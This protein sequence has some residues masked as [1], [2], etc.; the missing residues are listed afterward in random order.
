MLPE[1]RF[2]II[3]K[4]NVTADLNRKFPDLSE[5]IFGNP[6]PVYHFVTES[7]KGY[8]LVVVGTSGISLFDCQIV[9][10]CSGMVNGE[11]IN[12]HLINQVVFEPVDK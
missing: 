11:L 3:C 10:E 1:R 9:K 8:N 7:G 12:V 5:G 4:G 2:F 6:F